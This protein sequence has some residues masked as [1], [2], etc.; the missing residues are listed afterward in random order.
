MFSSAKKYFT[1]K[2]Q[3]LT[4]LRLFKPVYIFFTMFGLFPYCMK[5]KTK[6]ICVIIPRSIY[7]NIL[8][9]ITV[10]IVLCIFGGMDI[11]NKTIEI[12]AGEGA[13][14]TQVNY[15]LEVVLLQI[16]CFSSYISI[17]YY[18]HRLVHILN[19][20]ASTWLELP[21]TNN[22]ILENLRSHIIVTIIIPL[23]LTFLQII[24]NCVWRVEWSTTLITIAYTC[25]EAVQLIALM[26]YYLLVLMLV[27]LLSNVE[28]AIKTIHKTK[29]VSDNFTK[30][31]GRVSTIQ[32]RSI[33]LTCVK[34]FEIKREINDAFQATILLNCLQSFHSIVSETHGI[35]Y[36]LL[37]DKS[38]ETDVVINVTLWVL[39]SLMKI[40]AF[41][42][43]GNLI[44]LVVSGKPLR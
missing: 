21:S 36:G 24:M 23:F 37:V 29:P 6:H 26:F 18:R 40:Y 39:C 8:C 4:L 19:D 41:A 44:N 14:V 2:N 43:S 38:L 31:D 25:L 20:M 9:A 15:I 34:A 3:D 7:L 27:A 13:T 30:I 11:R 22:R 5:F 1:D 32:V 28:E 10:N 33:E 35:Y 16:S 17:Y 12:I 42:Y